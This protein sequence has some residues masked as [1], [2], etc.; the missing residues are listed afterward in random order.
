MFAPSAEFVSHSAITDHS[1][2]EQAAQDRTGYRAEQAQRIDWV[3][4]DRQRVSR[5]PSMAALPP[6]IR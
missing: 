5:S 3:G 2:Y 1:L 6:P 4:Q